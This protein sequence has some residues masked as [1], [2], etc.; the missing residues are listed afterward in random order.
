MQCVFLVV[1]QARLLPDIHILPC[2]FILLL[3]SLQNALS[4]L[5]APH[6]HHRSHDLYP[7][8]RHRESLGV[9]QQ[10]FTGQ[11]NPEYPLGSPHLHLCQA[12]P[13]AL[14]A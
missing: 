9:E 14:N 11:S 12:D 5:T 13:V 2:G 8:Q 10:V 1:K 4:Q 6:H 7:P 3:C